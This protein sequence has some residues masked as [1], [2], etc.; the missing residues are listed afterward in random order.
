MKKRD[1]ARLKAPPADGLA[2]GGE[3]GELLIQAA[4]EPVDLAS[5]TAELASVFRAAIEKAG[6]RLIVDCPPLDEPV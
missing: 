1:T 2:G 4:F 6:L 5:Y 3:L